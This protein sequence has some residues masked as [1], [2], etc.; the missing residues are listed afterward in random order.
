MVLHS[1]LEVIDQVMGGILSLGLSPDK[2]I[3]AV[4]AVF[5]ATIIPFAIARY[6]KW[7]D[8]KKAR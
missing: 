1:A 7:T 5:A 6:Q 2:I 8:E 3:A 4:H